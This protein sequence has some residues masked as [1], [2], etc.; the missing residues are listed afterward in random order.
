[1][2]NISQILSIEEF[3]EFSRLIRDLLDEDVSVAISDLDQFI[4]ITPSIELNLPIQVG[5]KVPMGS[6]MRKCMDQKKRL[7]DVIPRE[8]YGKAFRAI[9]NPITD[10]DG[11]I[12]GAIAIAK[13][14]E[15]RNQVISAAG[16]LSDSLGEISKTIEALAHNAHEI[17]LS[18]GKM[19]RSAE[20]A[21]TSTVETAKVLDFIKNIAN[22]TNLLG[23]NAAIEAARSG[24]HG[25]GFAVVA[26]E[27]RKLSAVSHEAANKIS[28]ILGQSDDAVKRIVSEIEEHS[29]EAM[30]QAAATEE[31]NAAVEELNSIANMLVSVGSAL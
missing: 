6:G 2:I 23:L 29:T 31:I 26:D 27:I 21:L 22:Q 24:E 19:V 13:S 10:L 28:K 20:D 30:Q 15:T 5:M 25:R 7:N 11:R 8:V 4:A 12:I 16:N 17:A 3:V 14:I 18:Q 9:S 1:M